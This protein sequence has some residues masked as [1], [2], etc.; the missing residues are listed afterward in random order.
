MTVSVADQ[1][2]PV[3]TTVIFAGSGDAFGSGGRLQACIAVQAADHPTVLLDC[4]ATS[5]AALKREG[6]EPNSVAAVFVSHL[7]VD[8]FGGVPLLILDGQFSRRTDP[9]T[10]AGPAG[11]AGRLDESL[12]MMFPGSSAVQRRFDVNVIELEAGASAHTIGP[13]DVQA[14]EVDHGMP[15]PSL[16]LRLSLAGKRIAY[17]G[18]TAWTDALIDLATNTDLFIAESYFWDKAVP[19]HLRHPDLAAHRDQLA[20][21]RIILTHM[22][23]DMLA[24]QGQAAF[25]VAYDGCVIEV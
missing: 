15:T 20:S 12:E 10:I 25:D 19:H 7:H 5:L 18:D 16:G 23:G 2:L 11:T 24:H 1:G 14:V 6:I 17:T 9:L 22:S 8:H 3:D 21:R 13:V 4:G